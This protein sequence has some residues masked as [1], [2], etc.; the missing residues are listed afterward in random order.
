MARGSKVTLAL[1]A[2][3]LPLLAQAA[4]FAQQEFVTGASER[5]WLSYAEEV[6]LPLGFPEW[7]QRLLTDPQTS[8]GLLVSCA[9]DRAEAIVQTIMA[10]GNPGA[11]TIGFAK[12][13]MPTIQVMAA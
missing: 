3:D 4:A 5:N 7:R 11:R 8:G 12:N 9:P 13:G 10:A 1:N 6:K 2:D